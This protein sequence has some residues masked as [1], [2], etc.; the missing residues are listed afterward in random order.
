MRRGEATM[1]SSATLLGVTL[2][3]GMALLV[4]ALTSTTGLRIDSPSCLPSVL[5]TPRGLLVYNSCDYNVSVAFIPRAVY[6]IITNRG[7][8]NATSYTLASGETILVVG[9][10]KAVEVNGFLVSVEKR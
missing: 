3:A 10:V 8:V 1:I 6:T 2:A 5:E 9:N 7:E 4:F